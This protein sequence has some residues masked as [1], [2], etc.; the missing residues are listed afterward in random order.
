MIQQ[1]EPLDCDVLIIG[2]GI[3]GLNA[4]VSAAD[5]GADVIVAEKANTLRS[6]SG[7]TGNDHF[8]CYIPE[9]HGG[10]IS[11]VMRE[12]D[13]SLVGGCLDSNLTYKF[14][15]LSEACVR[16]WDSW[17][18]DMRPSGGFEFTG[19]AMPG[20]PRIFLKYAGHNQ[21][22]VLTEQ[23]K[24]RGA[25]ILNRTIQTEIIMEEGRVAG[26]L[27]VDISEEEPQIQVIRCKSL[28]LA[29]G[30]TSRLYSPLSGGLMFNRAHCPACTGN[31]RAAAY[32]IGARLVNLDMAYAHAGPK[33]FNRCGKATWIGV[34]RDLNGNPVG[35]FVTKPT[36]ELGDITGDVWGGIFG[37]KFSQGEPVYM[38]CS[39][40]APEDLAYMKWGLTEEGNTSLLDHMAKEGIDLTKH[41]VEFCQYEP[42]LIGRGVEIDEYA[43]TNIPGL[44]AAGDETGN[45]R[46]DIAAGAVYGRVAGESAAG[47]ARTAGG[48]GRAEGSETVK[49]CA[50]FYSE[51]LGRDPG[52]G[53]ATWFE[54][55][56]A[57][58][59]IMSDYAGMEV[60][61]GRLFRAGLIY[62]RRLQQKLRDTL[63]CRNSHDFMRCMEVMDLAQ[64]GELLMLCADER[65]ESRGRNK[66]VDFPFSNPLNNNRFL[67]IE[68]KD[69]EHVLTWRDKR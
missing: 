47:Y 27:C 35:Q 9:V 32:R 4:A 13:E 40:T 18:I 17:G 21:K 20:R 8:Q 11:P 50:D 31:G 10:D 34:Y 63:G 39:E 36:K 62:L 15:T 49:R 5:H 19:H 6:G 66:R 44:Y 68:Q 26:S 22:K 30:N 12:M 41:M 42:M 1:K 69:G 61:S 25:R 29:T 65:K 14:L 28:I 2:G 59:Q 57:L 58:G 24:K 37:Y 43:A 33:Y 46:A 52:D 45:F 54:A 67:M 64:L 48:T 7:A 16:D 3:A 53:Y 55:N 56:V 23:A 60:R 38:D 51:L